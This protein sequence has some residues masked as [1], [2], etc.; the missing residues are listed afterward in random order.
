MSTRKRNKKIGF[1]VSDEE[2]EAI[3]KLILASGLS[4]QAY[5]V[6]AFLNAKVNTK[7]EIDALRDYQKAVNELNREIGAISN[8]INQIIYKTHQSETI[9]ENNELY[10]LINKLNEIKRD[11]NSNITFDIKGGQN[12]GNN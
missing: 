2:Y 5:G 1:W 3:Q 12:N 10:N 11:V 9:L 7:E 8:N 4:K 6:N